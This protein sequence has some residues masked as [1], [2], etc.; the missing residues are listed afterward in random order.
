MQASDLA[1]KHLGMRFR[2][3]IYPNKNKTARPVVTQHAG[4][5]LRV[6]REWTL[7]QLAWWSNGNIVVNGGEFYLYPETEVEQV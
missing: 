4:M 2:S 1:F 6:P 3:L 7:G 5:W